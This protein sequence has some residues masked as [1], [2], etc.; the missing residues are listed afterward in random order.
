MEWGQV[1]A[2]AAQYQAWFRGNMP[3]SID[4][5]QPAALDAAYSILDTQHA[6]T[7]GGQ[8]GGQTGGGGILSLQA[9]KAE[10]AHLN[11][12]EDLFDLPPTETRI[13]EDATRDLK[14]LK[15]ALDFAGTPP[16]APASTPPHPHFLPSRFVRIS[17]D[18]GSSSR[19][20]TRSASSLFSSLFKATGAG[21][22]W[23]VAYRPVAC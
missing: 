11:V 6:P 4:S 1:L 20:W 18:R 8:T 10:L 17:R 22:G 13:A 7:P 21:H 15:K 3:F 2:K 12:Q 23:L 9:L 14:L 5:L 19:R 16:L